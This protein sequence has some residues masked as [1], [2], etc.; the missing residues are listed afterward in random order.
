MTHKASSTTNRGGGPARGRRHPFSFS[1]VPAG[2]RPAVEPHAAKTREAILD[3]AERLLA[4]RGVEAASVREI[5]RAAGANL[6]AINYHF[7]TKQELVAAVF[8][9]RL[10]P[11][12]QLQMA[13][14]DEA[15]RKAGGKPPGLEAL[16][17]AMI[18]P[19]VER[20]FA[21][22]KRDTA[23]M[24]LVGRFYGDPD[25]E[26]EQRIR[27]HVQGVWVRFAGLLKRSLP[28]L[29]QEERL[30]RIKFMAGTL[31]HTLLTAGRE[32]AMPRGLCK[33]FE[34]ETL[35]RRLVTYTAAGMKAG[36]NA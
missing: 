27:A 33:G 16:L 32:R 31:H 26:I 3:A 20:S 19:S 24:R 28:E 1:A 5:T 13:L 18:R 21:A 23:F 14:L 15:E 2:K 25:P 17:E 22:G 11:V 8:A 9:R 29:S 36:T 10:L 7:G 35:I 34:A 12:G 30:W 4:E 6:G